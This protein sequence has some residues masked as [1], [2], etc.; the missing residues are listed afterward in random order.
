MRG[1]KASLQFPGIAHH[2]SL[3]EL[4]EYQGFK[5]L[6]GRK[7]RTSGL[8]SRRQG[9]GT[10][11]LNGAFQQFAASIKLNVRSRRSSGSRGGGGAIV[12]KF[13]GGMDAEKVGLFVGVI[14]GLIVGA[15]VD[16]SNRT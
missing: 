3:S 11:K 2:N 9:T 5:S 1:D 8:C 12:G 13:V 4:R 16:K 7:P 14:I 6:S 15:I 10:T